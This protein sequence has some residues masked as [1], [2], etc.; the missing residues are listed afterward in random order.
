MVDLPP[1]FRVVQSTAP[2]PR[3]PMGMIRPGNI[4]PHNRPTVTNSD[5]SISTVRTISAGIDGQEVLVPTVSPDGQILSDDA[6][7]TR[8]L[9]TGQDFGAFTTPDAANR[10]AERLHNSQA[11][12]YGSAPPA[13]PPGF[14]IAASAA[15]DPYFADLPVPGTI[16]PAPAAPDQGFNETAFAQGTSGINE[17]IAMALGAPVD[18]TN[19]ALR[20]GAAGINAATGSDIQ[21]PENAFGGSE[22][23]K[24]AIA[25]TIRPESENPSNQIIRRM[26]QELGTNVLPGMGVA[27]RSTRPIQSA[28]SQAAITLGSGAGAAAADQLA[29]DNPYAELVGSILGGGAAAGGL[30]GIKKAVTPFD[31]SPARQAANDVMM[32][33]GIDLSAGQQTGNKGLQYA[34]SELGGRAA[35]AL[36]ERQSEQ[37][38]QAALSR[39]GFAA[40]RAMPEVMDAAY[41]TIGQQFDDLAARNMII[42]DQQLGQDLGAV[43]RDYNSLV[44]DSARAPIVNSTMT[45]LINAIRSNNGSVSGEAYKSLRSQLARAARGTMNPE[46][47]QALQGIQGALDGAME[48]SIAANNPADAG[49]WQQVRSDYRNFLVIEQAAARAGE[50]TALG[51]ITPANLRSAAAQQSKRGYVRGQGDFADLARAGVATMTPLPNSGTAPR[52][53]VRNA[54]TALPAV[55]G[56]AVGGQ[57]GD[58]LG[59]MLGAGAGAMV[60]GAFGKMMMSGPGQRYLG[61]QVWGG[62]LNL[63]ESAAVPAGGALLQLINAQRPT[64][65]N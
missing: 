62:P 36:T 16:A 28:A 12:E 45:D 6:A 30:A 18:L 51:I 23:I 53:F 3:P 41:T 33:E 63:T 10:F 35:E 11:V 37:F 19:L 61:N 5:G 65:L 31:T 17:G 14:R 39:I 22:T 57:T 49:A 43:V 15:Q 25:P 2:L 27:A 1:G 47:K 9:S 4:D 50:N 52:Q 58:M 40:P 55:M 24:G 38:T 60:P 20:A 21:L 44:G 32:G 42:A 34:E 56:A 54:G 13:I 8:A 64:A 46:L 26:G 59:A 7:I 48:R 29:P